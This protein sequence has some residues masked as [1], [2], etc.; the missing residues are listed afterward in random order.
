MASLKAS[1][2]LDLRG[3]LLPAIIALTWWIVSANGLGNG[4]VFVTYD[5][6]PA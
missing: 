2:R 1:S 6:S 3:L 4:Y 5:R